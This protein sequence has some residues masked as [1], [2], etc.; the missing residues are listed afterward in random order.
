MRSRYITRHSPARADLAFFAGDQGY[1]CRYG[2][3]I[4]T[5][6]SAR[7]PGRSIDDVIDGTILL[8]WDLQGS[9]EQGLNWGRIVDNKD[10]M[11]SDLRSIF[12]LQ[13]RLSSRA[14]FHPPNDRRVKAWFRCRCMQAE[15]QELTQWS[16]EQM[17]AESGITYSQHIT[18][19]HLD[20]TAACGPW[21]HAAV[22]RS[23]LPLR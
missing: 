9:D 2:L 10:Y 19:A 14:Y 21:R 17:D 23:S 18:H 12:C 15:E 6:Y 13:V 7:G 1:I 22:H 5:D 20:R 8:T 11:Y 3:E 4:Q 16:A